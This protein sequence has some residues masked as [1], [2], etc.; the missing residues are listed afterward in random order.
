MVVRIGLVPPDPSECEP[1][2]GALKSPLEVV[3]HAHLERAGGCPVVI[4]E[5]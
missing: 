4:A 2:G 3:S 1:G 5:W